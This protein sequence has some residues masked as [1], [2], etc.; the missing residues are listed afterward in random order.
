MPADA[1]SRPRRNAS[2]RIKL[3]QTRTITLCQKGPL[4]LKIISTLCALLIA[5]SAG[6][7]STTPGKVYTYKDDDGTPREMEIYF[8]QD[9]DPDKAKVPGIIMFHGGGWTSGNRKQ[10]RYLCSYFASRGLVAATASYEL[11]PKSNK[12]YDG[13][14][15][16]K[17]V[18]IIDAKSA[19]RW[20]KKNADDLGI[21]PDRIIGGGGSAGGHIVLVATNNPGLNDPD[22]DTAVDTSV[23]AYLLFNPAVNNRKADFI[24]TEIQP[25]EHIGKD[26]PPAIAFWGTD[27]KWLR[28]WEPFYAE[29]KDKGID[30]VEVWMAK[31]QT[32]AFFNKQP[33]LDVT[34]AEADR[35]LVRQGLLKGEPTLPKPESGEA[36]INKP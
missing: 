36:L 21:D 16:R 4:M 25:M 30:S 33:W 35:F 34:I 1:A 10:F 8:P 13:E 18:C 31:G 23:V 28:G 22:D 7:Q 27:D 14:G 12:D 26:L 29:L 15:D 20:Y 3:S 24:D 9:H 2:D 11:A 19:I 17:R 32:H 5:A 6:A